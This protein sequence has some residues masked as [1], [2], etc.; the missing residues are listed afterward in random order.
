MYMTNFIINKF[1]DKEYNVENPRTR[2]QFG[3][4]SGVVGIICNT[5]LFLAKLFVGVVTS[6]IAVSADAFNNLADAGSSIV[7]LVCFKMA[8]NPADR[9]HPFGH[10]RIEYISGLIISVAIIITGLGFIKSSVEK[11]FSPD[12][13]HLDVISL[14]ILVLSLFLKLWMSLFNTRL[15]KIL[16][17]SAMKATAADCLIDVVATTAIIIS[18]VFTYFTSISIDAYVGVLVAGFIIFTGITMLNESLNPLLGTAPNPEL[19]SKINK[20]V[21]SYENVVGVHELMVHNYG[22]TKSIISLHVEMPS[23]VDIIKLH[24][25]I[26][27]IEN[28]LKKEFNCQAIIHMDPIVVD[29]ELVN[30][31]RGK[32]SE[33][34]K[35][36]HSK[37]RVCD[38]RIVPGYS[39][40]KIIFDLFIPYDLKATDNQIMNSL[41]KS[42]KVIDS[43]YDCIVNIKREYYD[44]QTDE[45][46]DL[47]IK[48]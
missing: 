46:E 43:S 18:M 14:V 20:L 48:G 25:I 44:I 23:N 16:R 31:V 8:E 33:M 40:S 19:I 15:G 41:E 32:V 9:K 1:I 17:S 36:I 39:V 38:L 30:E 11:I 7:T 4:L 37:A 42:I 34:V 2:K 35:L 3:V 28:R 47:N 22:P 13:V 26:D 6:S 10:G 12:D 27:S 29:D 24:E 5:I 21:L 45:E